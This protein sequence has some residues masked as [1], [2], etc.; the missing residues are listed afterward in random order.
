M[1][2]KNF[3]DD[4]TN[5]LSQIQKSIDRINNMQEGVQ[6]IGTLR[7]TVYKNDSKNKEVL[8]R[9]LDLLNKLGK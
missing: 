7:K 1:F 3:K 5:R 8:N 4:R 2:N 6:S 9:L